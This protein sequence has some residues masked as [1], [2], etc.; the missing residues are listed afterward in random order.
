MEDLLT[1]VEAI[2]VLASKTKRWLACFIDYFIWSILLSIV[3]YCF[4]KVVIEDDGARSWD[5]DGSPAFLAMFIIWFILL[6]GIEAMN[7]GQTIGKAIFG[8]RSAR[9]DG[10]K[11]SPG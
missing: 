6:P 1:D 8:I 11:I 5:L 9:M 4:G 10:S 2:P 7:G 3:S